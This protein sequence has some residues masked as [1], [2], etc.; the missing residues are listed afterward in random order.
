MPYC[1]HPPD[2]N[3]EI[4]CTQ[5]FLKSKLGEEYDKIIGSFSSDNNLIDMA[6]YDAISTTNPQFWDILQSIARYNCGVNQLKQ[7][8]D[9]LDN[10]NLKIQFIVPRTASNVD[11]YALKSTA[12][13]IGPSQNK[14]YISVQPGQPIYQHRQ[15]CKYDFIKN[16]LTQEQIDETT[17]FNDN[18]LSLAG[19]KCGHELSHAIAFARF[20]N[21]HKDLQEPINYLWQNE[22]Q[23]WDFLKN[24]ESLIQSYMLLFNKPEEYRNILGLGLDKTFAQEDKIIGEFDYLNEI[25]A[26]RNCASDYVIYVRMPYADVPGKQ[27][28]DYSHTAKKICEQKYRQLHPNRQQQE[29][30]KSC[31]DVM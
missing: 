25:M 22:H 12:S 13:L 27:F 2:I 20:Y 26:S 31:C 5:N 3:E 17:I 9:T 4:P 7:L 8:Q 10:T 14:I 18:D 30:T 11:E 21:K 16:E 15:I 19:Y 1:N 6:D 29:N 23:K 28:S 24:D